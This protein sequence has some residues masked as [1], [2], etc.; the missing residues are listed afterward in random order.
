M[1]VV[2]G[3]FNSTYANI[4]IDCFCGRGNYTDDVPYEFPVV[5][6]TKEWESFRTRQA[7]LDVCQIP[8]DKLQSMTTG[9]LLETVWRI[10]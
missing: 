9:A 4:F 10:R 5:P 8:E 7:M 2:T 3:T 1:N 6:N